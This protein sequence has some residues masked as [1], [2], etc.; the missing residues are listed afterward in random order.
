MC[1]IVLVSVWC[2][3]VCVLTCVPFVGRKAA[4]WRKGDSR[5]VRRQMGLGTRRE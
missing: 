4:M 3:Y 5:C 1:V 2:V